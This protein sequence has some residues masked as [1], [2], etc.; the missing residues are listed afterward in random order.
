VRAARSARITLKVLEEQ[1]TI[2]MSSPTSNENA[3]ETSANLPQL[4]TAAG[5]FGLASL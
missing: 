2:V 1:I 5:R 3:G 4:G